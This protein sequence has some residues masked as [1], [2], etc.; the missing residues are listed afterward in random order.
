MNVQEFSRRAD[1]CAGKLYAVAYCT[2]RSEADCED[3]VQEALLRAWRKLY[4]L[5]GE[6]FFETWLV[7]ICINESRR[8]LRR[9]TLRGELPLEEAAQ[10]AAPP[11]EDP[12]LRDAVRAME[13]RWRLPIVLHYIDGYSEKETA[14]ILRL[15]VST[16]KWR[17]R[18][19]RAR[20]RARLE[21]KEEAQ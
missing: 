17:L 9:R 13:L 3:A 5:R 6:E 1:A 21:E 2:L 11:P 20:L 8:I 18:E 4:A 7:R 10:A 14:A 12:A 16:V 15:P 19:G